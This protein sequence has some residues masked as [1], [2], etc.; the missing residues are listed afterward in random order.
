MGKF[1]KGIPIPESTH[2]KYG[3]REMDVGD[4]LFI[5]GKTSAEINNCYGH[6]KPRKFTSRRLEE[7]GIKGVR[8]WR[9]E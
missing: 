2:G 4:S 3:F 1:D 8:I 9:I 7:N 5:G 6:L